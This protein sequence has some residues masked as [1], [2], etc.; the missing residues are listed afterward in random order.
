M[1]IQELRAH[2]S[3]FESEVQ[4]TQHMTARSCAKFYK[5]SFSYFW[6]RLIGLGLNVHYRRQ[7]TSDLHPLAVLHTRIHA[8]LIP[9]QSERYR[10]KRK[11]KVHVRFLVDHWNISGTLMS[12][13]S[14]WPSGW[15]TAL[16]LDYSEPVGAGGVIMALVSTQDRPLTTTRV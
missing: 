3:H 9:L 4:S 16:N 13:R 5:R 1:T 12:S 14:R 15:L 11:G 6:Y 8:R 7:T 10:S 2:V